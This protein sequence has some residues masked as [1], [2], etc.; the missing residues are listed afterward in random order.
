[1]K[2][3]LSF[4]LTLFLL[5]PGALAQF[6]PPAGQ[7]NPPGQPPRSPVGSTPRPSNRTEQT[8]Q[9]AE[10]VDSGRGL[11]WFY[12]GAEGS[13]FWLGSDVFR[14][15]GG[16]LLTEGRQASGVGPGG[17]IFL[18]GRFYIL[19]AGAR[20]RTAWLPDS[21]FLSAGGEVGFKMPK[22]N[23]EPYLWLGGGYAT[24]LG[25][26]EKVR[27]VDVVLG[28]GVDYFLSPYV[29]IGGLASAELVSLRRGVFQGLPRSSHLGLAAVGSLVLGLHF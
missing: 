17:G 9:R 16:P 15:S 6:P 18:G 5:A 25:V 2:W 23:L 1:M 22:G 20:V 4:L 11:S 10:Q 21:Q 28:G 3:T 13:F 14:K 24:L 8:L 12:I 29:S 26:K 19:N 7:P 27:G